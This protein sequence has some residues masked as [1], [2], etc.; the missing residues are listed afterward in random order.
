MSNA[1]SISIEPSEL[2]Q[3]KAMVTQRYVDKRSPYGRNKV[4]LLH[5]ASFVATGDNLQFFPTTRETAAG[6]PSR[7]TDS[8]L[9]A[10][11][12]YYGIYSQTQALY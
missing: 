8:T 4:H 7:C 5:V 6:C 3:L 2:N 10:N 11:I 9:E 12:P 1:P